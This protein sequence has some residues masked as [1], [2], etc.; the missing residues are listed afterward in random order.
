MGHPS[1]RDQRR[2]RPRQIPGEGSRVAETIASEKRA[3]R[4]L[5]RQPLA[6]CAITRIFPKRQTRKHVLEQVKCFNRLAGGDDVYG[7]SLLTIFLSH[8]KVANARSLAQVKSKKEQA[9]RELLNRNLN[10]ALSGL[11]GPTTAEGF[12]AKHTILSMVVSN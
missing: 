4:Q 2:D 8:H 11:I 6:P 5:Q 1:H 12:V 10:V 3:A 9:T 7:A